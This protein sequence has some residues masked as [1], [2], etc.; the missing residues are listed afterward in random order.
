[1]V[2]IIGGDQ[3][4]CLNRASFDTA[5]TAV[6]SL[7]VNLWNEIG[8]MDWMQKAKLSGGNH[9]FAAAAT[10]VANKINALADIFTKLD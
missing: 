10:A 1:M 7:F 9:R 6:T 3:S 8:G 5:T 4:H 2:S